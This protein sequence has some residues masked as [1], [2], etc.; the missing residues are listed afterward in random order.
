MVKRPLLA[1]AADHAGFYASRALSMAPAVAAVQVDKRS[2]D[3]YLA[4]K[5][6]ASRDFASARH[7]SITDSNA[8]GVNGLRRQR[9]APSSRAIRRKSGAGESRFSKA[10]PDIATSGIA[11]ARS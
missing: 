4:S 7:S 2:G 9:A 5:A 8:A 1:R 3:R 6:L 11:G 10:Y